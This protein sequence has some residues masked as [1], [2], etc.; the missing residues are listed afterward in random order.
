MVIRTLRRPAQKSGIFGVSLIASILNRPASQGKHST[1]A[2]ARPGPENLVGQYE[3][4]G[5]LVRPAASSPPDER[6]AT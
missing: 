5:L 6:C 1:G 2:P 4:I 3:A